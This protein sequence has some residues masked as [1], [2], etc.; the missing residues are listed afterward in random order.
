MD[1]RWI[2][3]LLLL[4][5]LRRCS[6]ITII[7]HHIAVLWHYLTMTAKVTVGPYGSY[8]GRM[9]RWDIRRCFL[10]W[11]R[12]GKKKRAG[13][14]FGQERDVERPQAVDFKLWLRDVQGFVHSWP[15]VVPW[16]SGFV[17]ESAEASGKLHQYWSEYAAC[18]RNY[19]LLW[20]YSS[21]SI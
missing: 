20:N 11:P 19:G 8:D 7:I 3:S 10:W 9:D 12:P 13:S 18:W 17:D 5:L 14:K 2:I 15:K 21:Y 1:T 4:L 16:S 6:S